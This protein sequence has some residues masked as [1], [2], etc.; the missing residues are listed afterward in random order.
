MQNTN[1]FDNVIDKI[2]IEFN[3][4][5]RFSEKKPIYY[6]KPNPILPNQF[7]FDSRFYPDIYLYL[8]LIPET[9]QPKTN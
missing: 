2:T 8:H 6:Q 4:N 3:N 9:K 1:N 5:D 7:E